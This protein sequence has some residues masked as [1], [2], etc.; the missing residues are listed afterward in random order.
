MT[1]E[2]GRGVITLSLF[3]LDL[4]IQLELQMGFLTSSSSFTW[5][6]KDIEIKL[7][8]CYHTRDIY[9]EAIGERKQQKGIEQSYFALKIR[10]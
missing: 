3:Q 9:W 6:S 10:H 2:V 8:C 1:E 4:N 5:F 7:I